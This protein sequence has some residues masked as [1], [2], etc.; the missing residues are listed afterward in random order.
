MTKKSISLTVSP[1]RDNYNINLERSRNFFDLKYDRISSHKNIGISK[2]NNFFINY[3]DDLINLIFLSDVS[4]ETFNF[5]E[6]RMEDFSKEVFENKS[7]LMKKSMGENG[8]Q[9]RIV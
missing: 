3:N 2:E 9:Y 1:Q 5:W 6:K 4:D 8:N 7:I